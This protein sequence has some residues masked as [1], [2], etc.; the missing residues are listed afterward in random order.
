LK[1]TWYWTFLP[2]ALL[3]LLALSVRTHATTFENYLLVVP[4]RPTNELAKKNAWFGKAFRIGMAHAA[5][6][7]KTLVF[8]KDDELAALK[9]EFEL[10]EDEPDPGQMERLADDK[11]IALLYG[12]YQIKRRRIILKCKVIPGRNFEVRSFKIVGSP[13]ELQKL[14]TNTLRKTISILELTVSDKELQ[15]LEKIPGTNSFSAYEAFYKALKILKPNQ[16]SKILC[17]KA[18]PLLDRAIQLDQAF[19]PARAVRAYCRINIA[20]SRQ[21]KARREN[22]R[23][24]QKDI[25]RCLKKNPDNPLLQNAQVKYFLA[26]KRYEKAREIGEINLR[27][28]P[29]N[30]HNYLLLG[31][32]YRC[33]KQPEAAEK[34][35]IQGLDLQGTDL[36]K[37]PFNRELGLLLLKRNDKHAAI[38]LSEVLKLEPRNAKLYYLR[39]TAL[40]RLKRYMD[41]MAEIQ[42]TEAIKT[43]RELKLLKAQTALVLGRSF[44]EEGD[45]DRA[46]SYTSIALNIQP[47]N[48]ETL[49]LM[50]KTLR[51][52]GFAPEARQQLERAQKAARKN[53]A[54]DHLWLG[55]EFVA[56][57][58]K[59][60][61][62]KE[63]VKY[64]K[65]NPKAPERRRLI[66]LIRKLQ[67]EID[68]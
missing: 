6:T 4:L 21:G 44:F 14:F 52:K 19:V 35:L 9:E 18:L 63:Y 59:E 45:F 1:Q 37:K 64:L 10:G 3:L 49:L 16:E 7:L 41:V 34:I 61:G 57:G 40:Y 28:H 17:L 51:K 60:E 55:T 29:A 58:Y 26:T 50:A 33:L 31:Y 5:L 66:S 22:L 68:E 24:A 2:L 27:M 23:W 38:Y 12:S 15:A 56:Q 39:A 47:K 46:Y 43:W 65:M 30:Y 62:V 8:L 54:K 67:G 48:F 32:T 20:Q 11:D 36:Q 25:K 42:K 13:K 53:R